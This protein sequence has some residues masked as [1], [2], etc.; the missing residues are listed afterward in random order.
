M[1][2]FMKNIFVIFLTV[3]TILTVTI[4]AYAKS[5]AISL[6]KG[7]SR[8]Y[9]DSY[10]ATGAYIG[11]DT[12]CH[13]VSSKRLRA[14]FEYRKSYSLNW[15]SDSRLFISPGKTVVTTAKSTSD[16]AYYDSV[17]KRFNSSHFNDGRHFRLALSPESERAVSGT[18]R[19]YYDN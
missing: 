9:S 13:A 10:Y 2:K 4:C 17:K 16:L 11:E 6:D 12:K 3:F 14:Q 15:V 5:N 19:I 18:A 7:G 8:A 1:K